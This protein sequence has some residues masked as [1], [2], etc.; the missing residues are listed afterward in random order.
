[1]LIRLCNANINFGMQMQLGW[2]IVTVFFNYYYSKWQG[3][4]SY[5]KEFTTSMDTTKHFSTI[6]SARKSKHLHTH[7]QSHTLCIKGKTSK[8]E[9]AEAWQS[10]TLTILA[11]Q[12]T[13]VWL[14]AC[15]ILLHQKRTWHLE[16]LMTVILLLSSA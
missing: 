10:L 12:F 7:T 5:W 16:S 8:N 3:C 2:W 4:G 14:L 15:K 11:L 13:V 6:K 1:M 9:L